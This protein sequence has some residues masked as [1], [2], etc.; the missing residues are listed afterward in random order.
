MSTDPEKVRAITDWP[1]PENL[2]E[3]RSFGLCSYY[4]RFVE[5]FAKISAP[6]HAM[7]KK[8]ETFRWTPLRQ[9][10][11]DRLKLVLTSAPV[12]AM[13][14]EESPFLLDVDTAD[15]DRGRLISETRRRKGRG[16]RKLEVVEMRDKLLRD[17]QGTFSGGLLREALPAR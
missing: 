8:G 16:L 11:F 14:D 15:V 6:L 12:L 5:G 13:L 17:T 9:E 2:Q 1:T 3:V 4:R 10:A 7:T